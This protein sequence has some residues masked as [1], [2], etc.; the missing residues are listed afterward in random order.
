MQDGG[1]ELDSA[2]CAAWVVQPG[3]DESKKLVQAASLEIVTKI[4]WG[5]M[6]Q[7]YDEDGE[8]SLDYR[9][10]ATIVRR[11]CKIPA[12]VVPDTDL[13]QLF[14]AVDVDRSASID[15]QEFESFICSDALAQDMVLDI[16]SVRKRGMA[17]FY[18]RHR[19]RL[20]WNV[21][22]LGFVQESM[23]QLCQLWVARP[24]EDQV[25]TPH[26]NLALNF[27]PDNLRARSSPQSP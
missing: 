17:K 16:F 27:E 3:D 21:V 1:G 19:S 14:N 11:D 18:Q 25:S 6:F 4:G 7:R 13:R 22:C 10:F 2:E 26:P 23:F 5:V 24:E 8:G 9:E 15:A 20:R 12:A